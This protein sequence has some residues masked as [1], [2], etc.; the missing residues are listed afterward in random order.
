M[1]QS[2]LSWIN[3][4]DRLTRIAMA[5]KFTQI[6]NVVRTYQRA[7]HLSPSARQDAEQGG[8]AGE[9]LI[10]TSPDA[11]ERAHI[12]RLDNDPRITSQ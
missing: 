4:H 9:D 6:H 10:S 2:N 8:H 12:H 5:I 7:I 3:W 1:R 11:C